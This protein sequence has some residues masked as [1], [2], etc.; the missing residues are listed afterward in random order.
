MNNDALVAALGPD[1]V[2]A[3]HGYRLAVM[4]EAERRGLRLVSDALSGLVLLPGGGCT[5]VDPIDIRLTVEE[6]GRRSDLAGIRLTWGPAGGWSVSP[7]TTGG[8]HGFYAGPGAVASDLVPTPPQ[9]LDW[10]TGTLRGAALPPVGVEIDDDPA[11]IGRLLA[12]VD[13]ERRSPVAAAFAPCRTSAARPGR[14]GDDDL[15]ATTAAS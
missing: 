1:A 11:V 7:G 8:P 9:L 14:N 12:L 15:G 10:V 5:T 6:G 4:A 2:G 13:Q 3:V